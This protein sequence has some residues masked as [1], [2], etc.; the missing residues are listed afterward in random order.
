MMQWEAL[1]LAAQKAALLLFGCLAL[2]LGTGVSGVVLAYVIAGLSGLA[3]GIFLLAR[4]RLLTGN[5]R[6]DWRFMGYA[7]RHALPLTLTTLFIGLYFRIDITL[8]AKLRTVAE[9][10][11]YG[12]AHKCIE[13]GMVLPAIVVS[14]AFPGFAKLFA[15]DLERFKRWSTVL[16]RLLLATALPMAALGFLLAEPLMVLLFGEAYR[17]A[18]GPFRWLMLALGCIFINYLFSY[19]LISANRQKSNALI[20]GLAVVV[21]VL[22]NLWLIPRFGAEGAGMAAA[23]TEGFLLVA[24]ALAVRIQIGSLPAYTYMWRALLLAAVLTVGCGLTLALSLPWR[25]G[26]GIGV[27]TL[28]L[29]L[30][31]ILPKTE[32][33]IMLSG[34]RERFE[35]GVG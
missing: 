27:I 13:V 33:K 1:T 20:S 32:I 30:T 16:L 8:L 29:A 10:G 17:G 34:L 26:V 19:M 22:G 6:P 18:A 21:V 35:Q 5:W 28:G 9:V 23:L 7:L 2:F 25:L 14:A 12:A 11:W 31:G 4:N 15:E 3:A 24:Y